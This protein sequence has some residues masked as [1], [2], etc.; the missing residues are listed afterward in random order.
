MTPPTPRFPLINLGHLIPDRALQDPDRASGDLDALEL[1]FPKPAVHRGSG[2]RQAVGYFPG[3]YQTFLGH[4]FSL[5]FLALRLLPYSRFVQP[6]RHLSY[7][8]PY[9]AVCLP[10][11]T[12]PGGYDRGK[13]P[14]GF[15]LLR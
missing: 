4:F 11:G 13:T 7:P 15:K 9:P 12:P 5:P 3:S 10:P 6:E 2:H 8:V 14:R 1:A